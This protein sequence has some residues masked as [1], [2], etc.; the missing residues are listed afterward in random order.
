MNLNN[1][2]RFVSGILVILHKL[3][4]I[5]ICNKLHLNEVLLVHSKDNVFCQGNVLCLSRNLTTVIPQGRH[6]K[7]QWM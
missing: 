2:Y 3:K 6:W 1:V 5:H 7:R 4:G